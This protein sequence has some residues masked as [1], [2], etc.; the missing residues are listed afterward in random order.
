[1]SSLDA[2]KEESLP[3]SSHDRPSRLFLRP[4]ADWSFVAQYLNQDPDLWVF[5]RFGKL[6]LF[7]ILQLQQRLTELEHSLETKISEEKTEGL[8]ELLPD[9]KIALK[10]YGSATISLKSP[11]VF[12]ALFPV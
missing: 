9:I 5:R 4:S 3:Y 6:H 10:E 12:T 11:A 1:M 7:N 8:D 2:S